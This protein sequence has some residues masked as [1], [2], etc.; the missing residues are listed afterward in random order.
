MAQLNTNRFELSGNLT[1]DP[2]FGEYQ[3]RP[4][5]RLDV[6]CNQDFPKFDE[7]G[8]IV[9]EN[10][11][12]VYDK[13]KRITDYFPVF[14]H[15]KT[16]LEAAKKAF[17]GD[18]LDCV[19]RVRT[20]NEQVAEGV[21]SKSMTVNVGPGQRFIITPKASR[22]SDTESAADA[23]AGYLPSQEAEPNTIP[24]DDIPF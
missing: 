24:D 19:G 13:E 12:V 1:R 20:K 11:R 10:G 3:G 22:A 16:D 17:K 14:I 4:Y 18:R 5:A 6:A 9:R 8:N 2:S 23:M 15:G 21:W 7:Q